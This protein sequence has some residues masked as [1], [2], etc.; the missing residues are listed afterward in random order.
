M[1]LDLP[2]EE[3]LADNPQKIEDMIVDRRPEMAGHHR[4][5]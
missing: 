1:A 4:G 3:A 2:A 5:M